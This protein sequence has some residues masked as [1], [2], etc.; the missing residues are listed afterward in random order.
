MGN[1]MLCSALSLGHGKL[2]HLNW[3]HWAE[4]DW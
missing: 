4:K 2:S 1:A 3:N